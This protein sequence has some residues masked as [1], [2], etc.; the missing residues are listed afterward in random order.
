MRQNTKDYTEED[1]IAAEKDVAIAAREWETAAI[2][3][4]IET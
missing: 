3:S 4:A 2:S 1:F